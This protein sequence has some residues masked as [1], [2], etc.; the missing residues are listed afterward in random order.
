MKKEIKEILKNELDL[1]HKSKIK[2]FTGVLMLLLIIVSVV[3]QLLLVSCLWCLLPLL[4][5]I[6]LEIQEYRINT[7]VLRVTR[8]FH[9]DEYSKEFDKENN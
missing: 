5:V 2:V 1:V 9:D 7:A 3:T 4:F 8:Y 6:Y